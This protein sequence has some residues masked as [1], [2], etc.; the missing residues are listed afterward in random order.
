MGVLVL[1]KKLQKN[2]ESEESFFFNRVIVLLMF[3][4]TFREVVSRLDG[5]MVME[6]G[7][8]KGLQREF[9]FLEGVVGCIVVEVKGL[10]FFVIEILG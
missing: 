3:Y 5:N 2:L 8:Q 1:F 7:S 9:L 10:G 6:M 4:F